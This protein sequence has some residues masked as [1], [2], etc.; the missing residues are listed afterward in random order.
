M[1][2]H[3]SFSDSKSPQVSK[4][5]LSFL[6]DLDNAVV[7]TVSTRPVIC[8]F[9]SPC[10]KIVSFMFHTFSIP[11]QDPG[12]YHSFRFLSILLCDPLDSKVHDSASSLFFVD[13]Y[14]VWSFGCD[15]VICLFLKIPEEFIVSHSPGKILDCAY[16]I[17]SYGQISIS[18][19]MHSG[20]P[21]QPSCV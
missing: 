8:K 4:T 7:K 9:S 16:T 10:T 21:C 5:L 20:S 6:D 15:L 14:K 11:S 18:C 2:F 13:Y 17:C 19:T 3:W 12:T 1:A